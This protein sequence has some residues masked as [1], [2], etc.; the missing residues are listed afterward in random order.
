MNR[1]YHAAVKKVAEGITAV[2]E[3]TYNHE[4]GV[5]EY[6]SSKTLI[7]ELITVGHTSSWLLEG[8]KPWRWFYSN[9]HF[10]YLIVAPDVSI[11]EID[12][13]ANAFKSCDLLL[14]AAETFLKI[15]NDR[16]LP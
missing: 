12:V 4:G 11:D 13:G 10:S 1:D 3:P 5:W 14:D 2:L 7:Q 8:H 9:L 6:P 16:E 15:P